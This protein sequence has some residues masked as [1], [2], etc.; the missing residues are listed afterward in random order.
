ME[1][2]PSLRMAQVHTGLLIYVLLMIGVLGSN[3]FER[4]TLEKMGTV[5]PRFGT[6]FGLN[7]GLPSGNLT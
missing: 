1:D 6:K 7:W 3:G 5:V 4:G 2:F